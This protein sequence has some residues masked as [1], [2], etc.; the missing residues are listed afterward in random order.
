M[1]A[2]AVA[3]AQTGPTV[4]PAASAA[5]SGSVKEEAAPTV[6]P[7]ASLAPSVSAKVVEA[8]PTVQPPAASP[9]PSGSVKE[10]VEARAAARWQA[11]LKG[12]LETAYQ[13]LSPASKAVLPL[14]VY[15]GKH[16]IGMYRK[17]KVDAVACEAD[18]CTVTMSVTY[19]YKRKKGLVTP[20]TEKW[21]ISGGRA[22]YVERA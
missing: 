11:L 13:F 12:D 17:A 15:K 18:V 21:I 9:A 16:K 8:A 22:W 7:T 3:C 6:Q 2:L 20:L 19:D 5:P 10:E 14:D 4:Q 1:C